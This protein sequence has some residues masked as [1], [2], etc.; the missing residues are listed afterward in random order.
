MNIPPFIRQQYIDLN[1][2][3]LTDPVN[4]Y[5]QQLNQQLKFS[6]SGSGLVVPTLNDSQIT[7]VTSD[8]NPNQKP[9]GT[10]FYNNE[11]NQFQAKANGTVVTFTTT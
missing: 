7:N 2:G 8:N 11:T 3:Y 10:I 5:Q 9:D 1:T 6:F 4:S